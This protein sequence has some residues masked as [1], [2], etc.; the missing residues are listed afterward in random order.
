MPDIDFRVL[1]KEDF[2]EKYPTE[3]LAGIH[4]TEGEGHII[5]V[6]RGSSTRTKL[7]ETA[8]ARLGHRTKSGLTYDETGI[9][10]VEADKWSYRKLGRKPPLNTLLWS[11]A[12]HIVELLNMGYSENSVFNYVVGV[13]E[14]TG[15]SLSKRDKSYIWWRL[16]NW[17]WYEPKE[18]E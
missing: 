9:R 8:H 10:E 5:E 14:K 18:V 3:E 11:L 2:R 7:H 12:S 16:R 15:V 1:S 17:D 6:P 13:L 4:W